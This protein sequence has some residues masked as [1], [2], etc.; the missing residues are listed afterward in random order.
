[1]NKGGYG[2][3]FTKR[4]QFTFFYQT[5]KE[6]KQRIHKLFKYQYLLLSVKKIMQE[7]ELS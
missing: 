2:N 3:L 7:I 6:A 1:M 5:R 4:L